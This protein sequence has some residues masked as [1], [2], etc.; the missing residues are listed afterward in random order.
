MSSMYERRISYEGFYEV[1]IIKLPSKQ[2][3]LYFSISQE[4]LHLDV[5]KQYK[6]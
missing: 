1:P 4:D 2:E 3:N 6:F 5:R